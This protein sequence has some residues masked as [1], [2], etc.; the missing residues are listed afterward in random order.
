VECGRISQVT[1]A[2]RIFGKVADKNGDHANQSSVCL[3]VGLHQIGTIQIYSQ[4]E[5]FCPEIPNLFQGF[6]KCPE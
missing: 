5:S 4:I 3:F 2:E 1:Q 6:K